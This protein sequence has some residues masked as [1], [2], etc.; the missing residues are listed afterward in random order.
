MLYA[1]ILNGSAGGKL[2]ELEHFDD[3][4]LIY[5]RHTACILYTGFVI[6]RAKYGIHER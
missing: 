4:L 3:V 1:F 6:M 2:L 5:D